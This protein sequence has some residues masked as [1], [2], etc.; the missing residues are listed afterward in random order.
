MENF[1][2]SHGWV[3]KF[4]N[5]H[6]LATCVLTLES[7]SVSE[8]TVERWKE[9]LATLVNGYE[10]KNTYN[11]DETGLF[12]KLIYDRTLTFREEPCHGGNK[13]KER[14]TV[15]L[16][17]NADGSEK[18]LPLVIGR[19]KKPRCFKNVKKLPCE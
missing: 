4:K 16:C 2:A 9:D 19:S 14:L 1:S 5:R 13:S 15:L 12:Y 7:A 8:G 18:F 11:C 17:C 6:G 3:E 10:P